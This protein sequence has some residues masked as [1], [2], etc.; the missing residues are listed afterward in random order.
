MACLC[1]E[2]ASP[3]KQSF[4]D[5]QNPLF[6]GLLR[7]L[8]SQRHL[9]FYFEN[10]SG[11][12]L[13]PLA[14]LALLFYNPICGGRVPSGS[15]PVCLFGG[16][17]PCPRSSAF[18][19]ALHRT[20]TCPGGRC[21]GC[22]ASVRVQTCTRPPAGRP[23]SL[24]APQ[25]LAESSPQRSGSGGGRFVGPPQVTSPT[26]YFPTFQIMARK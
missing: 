23:S 18:T 17:R 9:D 2:G 7:A 26:F 15:V 21:Q 6:G 22:G 1:E 5:R 24:S 25:V 8:P 19:P 16:L 4:P 20:H 3:T 11:A 12:A 13:H 14:R 10:A